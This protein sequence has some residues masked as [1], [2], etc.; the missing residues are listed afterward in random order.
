[1]TIGA[2]YQDDHRTYLAIDSQATNAAQVL[3]YSFKKFDTVGRITFAISGAS[4]MIGIV[5][6]IL[7]D[8]EPEKLTRDAVWALCHTLRA[9]MTELGWTPEHENGH[10]YWDINVILV[11]GTSTWF[12]STGLVPELIP[13]HQFQSIGSGSVE[14]A[15]A[16]HALRR[17][18][19]RHPAQDSV[20]EAVLVTCDLDTHCGRPVYDMTID[21]E[22]NV[23]I[24]RVVER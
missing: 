7:R 1:M 20:L 12:I 2:V 10:P 9:K 4:S 3:P 23:P 24:P 11:D 21:S 6:N 8:Q 16:F 22:G 18:N 17:P 5:G 14:A 15:S 19:I 13:R